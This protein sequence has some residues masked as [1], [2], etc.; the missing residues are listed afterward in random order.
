MAVTCTPSSL[1]VA[2]GSYGT[3]VA[4]ENLYTGRFTASSSDQTKARVYLQAPITGAST[5]ASKEG[6]GPSCTFAVQNIA[7]GSATITVT[8][9]AGNTA[10]CAIT[11]S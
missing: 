11:A 6:F 9:D 5:G 2:S 7:T 4:S 8:D 1:T 10:T 3:F